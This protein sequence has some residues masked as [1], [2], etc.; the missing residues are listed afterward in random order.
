[1]RRRARTGEYIGRDFVDDGYPV[2]DVRCDADVIAILLADVHLSQ[3][4]PLARAVEDDWSLVQIGYLRQLRELQTRLADQAGEP[5]AVVIAGDVFDRWNSPPEL[6]NLA[7]DYLPDHVYAVP[8]QHDLPYHDVAR[9]GRSAFGTLVKSGK[10]TQ[11]GREPVTHGARL[12]MWG[13]PWKAE[14][15]PPRVRS[16]LLIELCVAHRYVHTKNS[17]YAGAPRDS[18]IKALADRLA[19]YHAAVFGDNHRP[20]LCRLADGCTVVNTGTFVRRKADEGEHRP[21]V[22][23]LRAD[24]TIDVHY[25]DVDADRF[26]SPADLGR[27]RAAGGDVRSFLQELHKLRVDFP[28]F[29]TIVRR[30]MD[31]RRVGADVRRIVVAALAEG[32]DWDEYAERTD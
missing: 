3:Q 29:P 1:M 9:V 31:E 4:A 18:L 19:G 14:I 13:F 15:S 21:H 8:G 17:G 23:L 5:V 25:L 11:L 32:E 27:V 22:G 28:D 2:P 26:S 10:I 24:G 20:F 7:L 12:R 6:I 30:I 16:D